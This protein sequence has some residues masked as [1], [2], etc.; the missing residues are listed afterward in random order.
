[1]AKGNDVL[2]MSERLQSW[3]S[4]ISLYLY[5]TSA[6]CATPV[7]GAG[8]HPNG[9][10]NLITD[11]IAL[12]DFTSSVQLISEG[13]KV[14]L[15]AGLVHGEGLTLWSILSRFLSPIMLGAITVP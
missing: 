12:F 15:G 11:A 14:G 9:Q 7:S 3:S 6:P 2:F 8:L 1:M 5:P 10:V 13:T 4:A